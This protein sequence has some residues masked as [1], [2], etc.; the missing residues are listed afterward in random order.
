[1]GTGEILSKADDRLLR[2]EELLKPNERMKAAAEMLPRDGEILPF[3][4]EE[5]MLGGW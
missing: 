5:A 2:A 1:M 3:A 4:L